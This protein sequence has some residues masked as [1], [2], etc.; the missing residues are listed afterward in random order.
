[1]YSADIT[2]EGMTFQVS[3]EWVPYVPERITA[4]PY[5][6][7]PAEGGYFEETVIKHDGIDM[8]PLLSDSVLD[9]ICTQFE[10]EY[11]DEQKKI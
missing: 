1:M 4:D 9:R 6:S 8:Y 3:G 11:L 5:N 2:V 7:V 10:K